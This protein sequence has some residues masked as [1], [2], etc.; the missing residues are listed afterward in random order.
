[1]SRIALAFVLALA[2]A[3]AGATVT[4]AVPFDEKVNRADAIILGECVETRSEWDPSKRFILTRSVFRVAE[5]LKGAAAAELTIV[6]PGGSVEGIHQD[7]IGIPA[8]REGD[9]R[10]LFVRSTRAGQT[11]LYFDQGTYDVTTDERGEKIV[12][13]VASEAVLVD[14]QRGMAVRPEGAMSLREFRQSVRD[15]VRRAHVQK[16]RVLEEERRRAEESSLRSILARNKA[17][18]ALALIG[19]ALATWQLLKRS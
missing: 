16:M 13:P 17:L 6:T 19:I 4:R 12:H 5:S 11:L 7:S 2:S 3:S 14:T 10:V 8:F 15:S 1:M 9:E 18:V